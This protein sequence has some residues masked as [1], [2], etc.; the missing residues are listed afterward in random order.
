MKN[1][2]IRDQELQK[3]IDLL[4]KKRSSKE[5][6]VRKEFEELFKMRTEKFLKEQGFIGKEKRIMKDLYFDEFTRLQDE[7]WQGCTILV[8]S[9]EDLEIQRLKQDICDFF[10]NEDWDQE[11]PGLFL[12]VENN[13]PDEERKYNEWFYYWLKEAAERFDVY[14]RRYYITG[15]M[16]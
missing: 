9:I 10:L 4:Y 11:D 5:R 14:I 13:A 3:E 6:A 7:E 15:E 8:D 16:M 1:E 12:L 2:Y